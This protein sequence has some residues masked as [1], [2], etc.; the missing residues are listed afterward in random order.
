MTS[1]K[2]ISEFAQAI[3][4]QGLST[5]SPETVCVIWK[6]NWLVPE[7]ASVSD[8]ENVKSVLTLDD[9]FAVDSDPEEDARITT[10][11]LVFKCIGTTKCKKY[12]EALQ[13]VLHL[14]SAGQTV[15]V[16]LI[17]ERYNPRDSQALAFVCDIDDKSQTIG[18]V[19]S[20]LLDE[21][22]AAINQHCILSV[23]F[24]WVCYITNWSKS[25]PGFFAGISIK[26]KG[27]WSKLAVKLA[28]TR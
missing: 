12:Q 19:V 10:Q 20:Q 3:D 13:V 28:S 15:P 18:Y 9:L 5:G 2:R 11:S 8:D 17:H 22:H 23:Q 14:I 27:T 7:V 26:R 21:V 25:G 4:I 1:N 24:A 6:W 16:R